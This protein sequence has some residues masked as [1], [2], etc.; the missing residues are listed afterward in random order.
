MLRKKNREN[1]EK[2]IRGSWKVLQ[3]GGI[4][5][6]M[7]IWSEAKRG[8]KIVSWMHLL[9]GF[10]LHLRSNSPFPRHIFIVHLLLNR[11]GEVNQRRKPTQGLQELP[12]WDSNSQSCTPRWLS[13]DY[14]CE[15]IF[16]PRQMEL[17]RFSSGK[18]QI[19]EEINP[20]PN[21]A[22]RK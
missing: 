3:E 18:M 13:E 22:C 16:L 1:Q 12:L 20:S 2:N 21:V 10:C 8:S 11:L 15:I 6:R 7:R 4:R 5:W 17:F 9:Q 14:T 19:M